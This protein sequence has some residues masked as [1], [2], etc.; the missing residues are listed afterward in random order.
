M[1]RLVSANAH[2]EVNIDSFVSKGAQNSFDSPAFCL[3]PGKARVVPVT[4][5][6]PVRTVESEPPRAAET[7]TEKGYVSYTQY[8]LEGEI[9]SR[10]L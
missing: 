10:L 7:Y 5:S 3:E 4:S 8:Q 2:L 6:P 1:V 9:M